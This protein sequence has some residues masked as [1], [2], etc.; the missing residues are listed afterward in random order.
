MSIIEGAKENLQKLIAEIA[1]SESHINNAFQQAVETIFQ[2]KGKL[3]V[4]GV[5]KTGHIGTKLAAT[6]ASTGTPSFFMHS[7]EAIHGDLGMVSSDDVVIAI[8]NSGTSKELV[9]ILPAIHQIGATIIAL[10]GNVHSP[11][12]ES[13]DVVVSTHIN[14]ELCPLNLAPTTSSTVCLI[15]GDLIAVEVMKLRKFKVENFALYHP[16][17]AIGRRLLMRISDVMRTDIPTLQLHDNFNVLLTNI[18]SSGLGAVC[19]ME[20]N[21][22]VGII[23]DGDVRRAVNANKEQV[24]KTPM[25]Q[26]MTRQFT[27]VKQTELAFD[28]LKQMENKKIT[29]IPVIN[30]NEVVGM[31][32]LHDLHDFG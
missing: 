7:T 8:S 32:S 4:T 15:M 3:V 19:V 11:L 24:F 1:A 12:A 31:V 18:S 6:F 22:M 27:S 25:S 28:V 20:N 21:Q 10:T 26:I 17:G 9:S 5:G 29:V 2:A 14:A 23:T 13:S 30:Q 16:G